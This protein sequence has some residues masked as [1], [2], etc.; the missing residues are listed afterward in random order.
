[1]CH[2]VTTFDL[3]H[4]VRQQAQPSANPSPVT[5]RRFLSVVS[6]GLG[7]A[8]RDRLRAKD[9]PR[10]GLLV[11]GTVHAL[12]QLVWLQTVWAIISFRRS[13][14]GDGTFAQWL[15]HTTEWVSITKNVLDSFF[16]DVPEAVSALFEARPSLRHG[17]KPEI[18]TFF[19]RSPFDGD[20]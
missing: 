3:S 12:R 13:F 11:I 2:A 1:A 19:L 7:H 4:A 6:K 20:V 16:D 9:L 14:L 18:G 5:W 17:P 8:I 10:V 15:D